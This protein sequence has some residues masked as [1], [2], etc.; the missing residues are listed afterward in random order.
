MQTTTIN[1]GSTDVLQLRVVPSARRKLDLPNALEGSKSKM[2]PSVADAPADA[3]I[4][5]LA[6]EAADAL[7]K[8]VI[9]VSL[10]E[11]AETAQ[12]APSS[13]AASPAE[14]P[15]ALPAGLPEAPATSPAQMPAALPAAL[16]GAPADAA[17]VAPGMPA[18]VP[19]LNLQHESQREVAVLAEDWSAGWREMT[20][21]IPRDQSDGSLGLKLEVCWGRL[22]I[23]SIVAGSAAVR[24]SPPFQPGDVITSV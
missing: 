19:P 24:A 20:V 9:A 6:G 16:P 1:F 18:R 23:S 17:V 8:A 22:T 4:E 3:S 15:A 13:S 5:V 21:E 7:I 10:A 11:A 14:T 2:T 12:A